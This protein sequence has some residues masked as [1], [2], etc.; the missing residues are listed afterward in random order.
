[1]TEQ[2]PLRRRSSVRA[3]LTLG[4]GVIAAVFLGTTAWL[5]GGFA[6]DQVISSARDDQVVFAETALEAEPFAVALPTASEAAAAFGALEEAGLVGDFYLLLGMS[7]PTADR[8]VAVAD[9][10]GTQ[11]ALQGDPDDPDALVFDSVLV[12]DAASLLLAGV[13]PT[14]LV[15]IGE[16]STA[17]DVPDAASIDVAATGGLATGGLATGEAGGVMEV[18]IA[19]FEL[20]NVDASIGELSRWL[21]LAAGGLTILAIAATWLLAGRILRPV[22]LITRRVEAIG[23]AGSGSGDRVPVPDT[24]DEIGH[25]AVTMNGMLE[26]LDHAA[27]TQRRFAADAS[28]ELRSPLAVIRTEAEV[29][30]AHPDQAE[31]PTIT[32]NILTETNRLEGL[33][34]DLLTLARHDQ[35]GPAARSAPVVDVDEVVMHEIARTRRVPVDASRVLAGRVHAEPADVGRMVRHLLDNAAR[36]AESRVE[37]SL[38]TERSGDLD[39][40]VLRV[41]DDGTGVPVADRH[42]IFERFARLQDARSRDEGGAGLGLAVVASVVAGVHGTVAVTDAPLGGARFEIR[43]PT[44]PDS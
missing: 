22:E 2:P 42:T 41:D 26:R 40:V 21:W 7:V 38:T 3:R 27:D 20:E 31:W 15:V 19:P 9:G 39:Q 25:L 43:L 12:S 36:H 34:A 29:A 6:G 30:L 1:M 35:T 32:R 23:A 8:S 10:T 24:R 11:I 13:D 14:D 16:V 17:T 33:V 28:H 4:V 44:A 5:F 37:V 18:A